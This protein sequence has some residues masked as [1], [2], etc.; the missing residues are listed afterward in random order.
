MA[1]A[2]GPVERFG[3]EQRFEV[4][5]LADDLARVEKTVDDDGDPGGVI[6]AVLEAPQALETDEGS[7]LIPDVADYSTHE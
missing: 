1:D 3:L 4:I 6:A 5:E 2:D 7:V